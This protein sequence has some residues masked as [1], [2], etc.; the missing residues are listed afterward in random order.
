MNWKVF[1]R[2]AVFIT[3]L[4]FLTACDGSQ[5]KGP[6]RDLPTATPDIATTWQTIPLTNVNTGEIFTIADFQGKTVILETMAVWCPLCKQ[7]QEQVKRALDNLDPEQVVAV[8]LDVDPAET[9]DFLQS[10]AQKEG[11]T[12]YYAITQAD[13]SSQL[14]QEFGDQILSPTSTPI[15]IIYPDGSHELMPFGVKSWDRLVALVEEGAG[16]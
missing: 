10:F 11:Y 1:F 5:R 2:T 3:Y 8:A 12:W 15:I 13:L 16:Q 9:A 7:Q 4:F 14:T 6:P